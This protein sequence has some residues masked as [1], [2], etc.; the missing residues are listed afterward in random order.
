M[1][2]NLNESNLSHWHECS[3]AMWLMKEHTQNLTHF[4]D[5]IH[6]EHRG[7]EKDIKNDSTLLCDPRL[8]VPFDVIAMEGKPLTQGH[9][10]S[11]STSL[12]GLLIRRKPVSIFW[13]CATGRAGLCRGDSSSSR[14]PGY[15]K[16]RMDEGL[17]LMLTS[18]CFPN[19]IVTW[20]SRQK[21]E[22]SLSRSK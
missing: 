22:H 11:L 10:S 4:G 7:T 5:R 2:G 12:T 8:M 9:Y 20:S 17:S 15:E 13:S 1:E 14:S 18:L 6:W 21:Q 19:A 3:A 16:C